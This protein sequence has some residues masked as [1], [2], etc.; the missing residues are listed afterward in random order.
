[1]KIVGNSIKTAKSGV[2]P[3]LGNISR[4]PSVPRRTHS[5]ENNGYS[6]NAEGESDEDEDDD[7]QESLDESEQEDDG[8]SVPPQLSLQSY[9]PI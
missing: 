9:F 8:Q 5:E 1:M 2:K 4:P 6:R 7:E 3:E